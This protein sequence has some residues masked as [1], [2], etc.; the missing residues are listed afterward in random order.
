[1]PLNELETLNLFTE[2]TEAL[3]SNQR[4][5]E[6]ISNLQIGIVNNDVYKEGPDDE[7]ISA[8]LLTL[9]FFMQ[10]NEPISIRNMAKL[11]E[12][13]TVSQSYKDRFNQIRSDLNSFLDYDSPLMIRNRNVENFN[14]E[15]LVG[16]APFEILSYLR[17]EPQ[18][19]ISISNRELFD[20]FLYG[21]YSH[22]NLQKREVFKNYMARFAE[23]AWYVFVEI[24]SKIVIYIF[25]IEDLNQEVIRE[26]S[27]S[28]AE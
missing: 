12:R 5:M 9:R 21:N 24:L 19:T 20:A 14:L 1:M 15:Q 18:L 27:A 6:A 3:K 13:L 4:F 28:Q 17:Q 26:L 11:Y 25:E 2:K 8:C 23:F 7:L 10:D 16:S 22:V